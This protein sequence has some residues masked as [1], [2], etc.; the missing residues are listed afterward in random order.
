MQL[1]ATELNLQKPLRE[2]ATASPA[3][4]K[5]CL[6]AEVLGSCQIHADL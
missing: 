6:D 3:A 4:T 2:H 1:G 5:R